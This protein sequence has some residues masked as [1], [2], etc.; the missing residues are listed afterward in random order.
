[1]ADESGPQDLIGYEAM[2]EEALRG[3]VRSALKYAATNGL[4]GDHHFY[5]TFK[6]KAPGVSGPTD[7]MARYP[8]EMTVVLRGVQYRDLAP[9]ET[10]FQVTLAFGGQPKSLSIP[11]AAIT[12]FA[13]PAAHYQLM[14]TVAEPEAPPAPAAPTPVPGTP[15]GSA[16]APKV[17][18]LDQFRKK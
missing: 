4:P 1:M 18:S 16:D 13:D 15:S 7:V 9:G 3:V 14:F 11:Y 12:Q 17:V 10:Y 6:T 2:Q 8:E 5:I